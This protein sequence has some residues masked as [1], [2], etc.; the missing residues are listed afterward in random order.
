MKIDILIDPSE[1]TKFEFAAVTLQCKALNIASVLDLDFST[2]H[3]RCQIPDPIILDFLFLGSV[4]Y[5]VDKLIS[6]KKNR[7]SMDPH[8]G[9]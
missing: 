7:R 8:I 3:D 5:S 9:I 2:L 4:V 1:A 6:R